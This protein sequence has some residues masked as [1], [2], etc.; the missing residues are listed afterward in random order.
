MLTIF[1]IPKSF[2]GHIGIIQRNAVESWRLLHPDCEIILCGREPGTFDLASE[3]KL[4]LMPDIQTNEYGTP[5]LNSVFAKIERMASFTLLCYV[6]CDIILLR[7][8][9]DAL[10]QVRFNKFLLVGQRRNIDIVQPLSFSQSDW[11]SKLR[12]YVI[13]HGV[14][15]PPTGIDYFIFPKDKT[16]Q[17]LPAFAVGRPGWDNWFIYRARKLRIP[18]I[19]AT[20]TV[21][22]IHQNHDYNHVPFARA[23]TNWE[24]PEADKN[25]VL[26]GNLEYI[27]TIA[28][29][30]H[31]MTSTRLIRVFGAGYLRRTWCSLPALCPAVKPLVRAINKIL[32]YRHKIWAG[33]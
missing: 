14:L 2:D 8:L 10:K 28:D 20:E 6:N 22:A 19:D 27:F 3:L 23:K 31:K 17:E 11:E 18:V 30:T 21:L 29:A 13:T 16:L 15:H 9:I 4:R 32:S 25:R 1:S 7:D 12:Q 5:L 26:M 33:M 24:G